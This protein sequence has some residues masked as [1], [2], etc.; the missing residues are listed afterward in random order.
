[1][2]TAAV[3]WNRLQAERLRER[4]PGAFSS[5]AYLD[6]L[7][8]RIRRDIEAIR[9][10]SVLEVGG[11]DRP[12]LRRGEGYRYDGLDIESREGCYTAYDD[13]LVQSV[14]E[15]IAREYDMIVSITLLEHVPDN[16][17]AVRSMFGALK[18]GGVTHHYV[19]S[20]WH[21]YS[22]CLRLVG[23]KWQRRLIRHLRPGTEDVTGYP[24]FFDHC[25]VRAMTRLFE[26]TGFVDIDVKPYYRANDY[27]AW[28]LP[29]YLVVSALENL[30]SAC[31]MSLFA[32]G[33]V[34]S[35]RKPSEA[36][37][38]VRAPTA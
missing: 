1:M 3:R 35:A 18:P 4:F 37:G 17:A 34:I 20:K 11:I 26:R 5:P 38:T 27:F 8:A 13:F 10:R 19:P 30:C 23:P 25:S 2:L 14:E 6:E 9:P 12:L 36:E 7:L 31:R 29:A 21:P 22:I 16:A 28:C 32:S 15:P 24:A 33:F